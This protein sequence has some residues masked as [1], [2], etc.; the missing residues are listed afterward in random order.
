MSSGSLIEK[1]IIMRAVEVRDGMPTF[2][3]AF[4]DYVVWTLGKRD[5]LDTTC[6]DWRA[7]LGAYDS[8]LRQVSNDEIMDIVTLFIYYLKNLQPAQIRK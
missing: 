8:C 7:I 6:N 4:T 2:M 5:M 1:L 3:P